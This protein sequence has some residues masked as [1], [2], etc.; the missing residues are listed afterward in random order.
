MGIILT[1]GDVTF[2][3]DVK[4]F[5]GLIV[6]GSKIKVDHP[7]DFVANAEIVKTVLATADASK[8]D[9]DDYSDICEIFKD[10]TADS[11]TTEDKSVGSIEIGDVLQYE[12]WKKNVE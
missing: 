4:R 6:S 2:A 8:G 7:M 10:Y 11:T 5:E 3:S 12:N 9:A 1:K